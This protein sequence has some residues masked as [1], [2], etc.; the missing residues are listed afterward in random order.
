MN[1]SSSARKNSGKKLEAIFHRG[2]PLTLKM[3]IKV[4]DYDGCRLRLAA[5]FDKN[6][7]VHGTGFAGSL[8][9]LAA[10]AGWGLLYLRLDEEK[11]QTKLVIRKGT[12]KYHY[13]VT[14]SMAAECVLNADDFNRFL[15][16]LK[17]T[18]TASIQLKSSIDCKAKT[19]VIFSGN[20][21]AKLESGKN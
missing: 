18:N 10:C 11:L 5:D 7:N 15:A 12:I 9:S 2:I 6:R 8:Y 4:V 14:G 20:Y 1:K 3:G 21:V 19:A 13:E 17:Q 16:E